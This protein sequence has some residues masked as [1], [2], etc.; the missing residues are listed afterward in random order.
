MLIEIPEGQDEVL[1]EVIKD[2]PF[3]II[4]ISISKPFEVNED[5]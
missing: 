2:F 3:K 5:G 1:K 4:D